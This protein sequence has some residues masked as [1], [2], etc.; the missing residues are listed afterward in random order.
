VLRWTSLPPG[1]LSEWV[2]SVTASNAVGHTARWCLHRPDQGCAGVIGF[3][4]L[5]P[6][7]ELGWWLGQ[8]HRGRN[9]AYMASRACLDW[10]AINRQPPV[11]LVVA[12]DN[13]PSSIWPPGSASFT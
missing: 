7:P 11:E 9:L 10:A 6:T 4:H 13:S 3:I 1:D 5:D 2:A 8:R 12:K